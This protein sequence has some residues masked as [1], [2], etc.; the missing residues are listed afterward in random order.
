MSSLS[1]HQNEDDR[2]A[3][4]KRHE[5]KPS[6]DFGIP[7]QTKKVGLKQGQAN[8]LPAITEQSNDDSKSISQ[9]KIVNPV[10]GMVKLEDKSTR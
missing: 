6:M 7:L 2:K 4:S 9:S 8:I 5:R 1:D 3:S 10:E